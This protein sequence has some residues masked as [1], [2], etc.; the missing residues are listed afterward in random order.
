MSSY[1]A[2]TPYLVKANRATLNGVDVVGNSFEPGEYDFVAHVN[3]YK[4]INKKITIPTASELFVLKEDLE[5]LPRDISLEI[6]ANFPVNEY[7]QADEVLVDEKKFSGK[8]APGKNYKFVIRKVGYDE[9][10]RDIYVDMGVHPQLVKALLNVKNTFV[11]LVVTNSKT[12]EPVTEYIAKINGQKYDAS[13]AYF[14]GK[15][16]LSCEKEGYE[17]LTKDV[18]VVPS[19]EAQKVQVTLVPKPEEK[20]IVPV[21]V[22]LQ[23]FS[24]ADATTPIKADILTINDRSYMPGFKI[25][26]GKYTVVAYKNGHQMYQK[27][28]EITNEKDVFSTKVVLEST[29]R[30]L[31]IKYEYDVAPAPGYP[32]CTVTLENVVSKKSFVPTN[33]QM[34]KPGKYKVAV[35]QKGYTYSGAS[36]IFIE[37]GTMEFELK[38]PLLLGKKVEKPQD[39]KKQQNAENNNKPRVLVVKG[40]DPNTLEKI[41]PFKVFVDGKLYMNEPIAVGKECKLRVLFSS[42]KTYSGSTKIE[43]GQES[44]VLQ[45]D[46]QLL[47]KIVLLEASKTIKYDN[48]EYGFKFFADDKE[49]PEHLVTIYEADGQVE[50]H[51]YVDPES[52][53]INAYSG[54]RYTE[55]SLLKERQQIGY[56]ARLACQRLIK[57]LSRVNEEQG[58]EAF[59]AALDEAMR[60]DSSIRRYWETAEKEELLYFL[61]S[62]ETDDESV[63]KKIEDVVGKLERMLE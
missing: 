36:D 35:Q 23:A 10:Q 5:V 56:L 39:D 32:E 25:L 15:Y 30:N 50:F 58:A 3:G 17:T 48:I 28:I 24:D 47:K 41:A 49:I 31:R 44:Q 1:A 27:D 11:K 37:P 63:I 12:N 13:A 20:K 55:K 4:S 7:L 8:L 57:H 34:I 14:P 43:P 42:Y 18:N 45:V 40:V 29:L 54:Y 2:Q 60:Y 62:V 51:L 16:S 53:G 6:L 59:V 46:L 9:W 22:E 38:I 33:G 52:K 19:N 61:Q 21:P 26:P